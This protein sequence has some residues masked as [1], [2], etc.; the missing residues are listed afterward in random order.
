MATHPAYIERVYIEVLPDED[1][2]VSYLTQ[3]YEEVADT[4]ERERYVYADKLRLDAYRNGDWRMAGTRL[5][6][7]I[8]MDREG[9]VDRPIELKSGG[10]WGIESDSG[11][12]Y[13]V[14]TARNQDDDL[15]SQLEALR[16]SQE[17]ID[18]ALSGTL[19]FVDSVGISEPR[20][21][22]LSLD[23]T[24]AAVTSAAVQGPNLGD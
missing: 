19:E 5:V 9:H 3:A 16:F 23:Q 20:P 15:R 12:D 13:F 1:P 4:P 6:A 2:D 8:T 22:L 21:E 11:R 10:I 18:H 24:E 7:E 14:E 17:E